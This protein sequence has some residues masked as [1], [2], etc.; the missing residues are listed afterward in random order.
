M[1]QQQHTDGRR[2]REQQQPVLRLLPLLE[3]AEQFGVVSLR[4][5][6]GRQG[7]LDVGDDSTEIPSADVR[8]DVDP[9]SGLLVVDVPGRRSDRDSRDRLERD[10]AA[11][12]GVDQEVLDIRDAAATLR[13]APDDDVVRLA[14]VEDVT[15]LFAGDIG[16][17]AAG[18][19]RA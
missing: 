15:D 1:Q 8:V 13:D 11:G 18:R 16:G 2:D 17:G 5:R 14:V 3:L 19:R 4:E 9:P 10:L 7:G 12:R 6:D